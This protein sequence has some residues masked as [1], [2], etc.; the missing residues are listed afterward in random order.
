MTQTKCFIRYDKEVIPKTSPRGGVINSL[1]S[2]LKDSDPALSKTLRWSPPL[3]GD[4]RGPGGG[5]GD[6]DPG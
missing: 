6:R 1:I 4:R 5:D 2:N 3:K